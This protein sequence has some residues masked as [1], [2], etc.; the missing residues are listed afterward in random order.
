VT[1]RKFPTRWGWRRPGH[2]YWNGYTIGLRLALAVV[3]VW[4]VMSR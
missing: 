4:A 2:P 3:L 1:Y